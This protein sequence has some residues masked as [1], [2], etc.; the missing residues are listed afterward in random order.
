MT[1]KRKLF[2]LFLS[3]VIVCGSLFNT[4]SNVFGEEEID[5]DAKIKAL[6]Q[7]ANLLAEKNKLSEREIDSLQG[8]IAENNY[9]ISLVKEEINSVKEKIT[10]QEQIINEQQNLIDA[11]QKQI[12]SLE[13][14]IVDTQLEIEY[15]R[16]K[17]DLLNKENED[18]IRRFGQI[19][20][21]MYM[22]GNFDSI[23]ML[24]GATDFFDLLVRTEIMQNVGEQNAIFMNSLISSIDDQYKLIE[25]LE[26]QEELLRNK[27]SNCEDE[28]SNLEAELVIQE[29]KKSVLNA[30]VE[31]EN[32]KLYR[33]AGDNEELIQMVNGIKGEIN[34]NQKVIDEVNKAVQ[35][36]V[37]EKQ[38][39][40]AASQKIYS[41]D[42]FIWP[43]DN[44]FRMITTYYGYDAWRGGNHYG[45]DIG[46]SGMGGANIYAA[47]SGT[48]ILAVI[49]DTY[50]GGYGNYIVIDHGG[51]I[52]TLYAH[53]Q[54]WSPR[55]TEGDVVEQGA[56]LGLVG[57]TGWA[58]GNH[59][60]FE[61]RV[62][63]VTVDPFKY[64]YS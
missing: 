36:L 61:V 11:K 33:H 7:Q 62:D 13:S 24:M 15:K 57:R 12:E 52:S 35:A 30:E 19:V 28:K 47:Q 26:Q 40:A 21:T 8:D 5:Y 59:L 29:E 43:L 39:K 49:G 1:G 45:I 10:V 2:T 55:F 53:M 6:E 22:T 20:K 58:T 9:V 32:Q 16:E 27:I 54:A 34:E 18:N 38:R 46:N 14:D 44:E 42:G 4:G 51:G 63:G 25:E 41:T 23:S 37:Q 17:I 50:G 31:A 56:V 3:A 60:H 64:N 48:V